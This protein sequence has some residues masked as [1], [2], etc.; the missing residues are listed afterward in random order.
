MTLRQWLR[1]VMGR[2]PK[3]REQSV[4]DTSLRH[5]LEVL[6]QDLRYTVRVIRRTG[7]L[8]VAVVLTLI[9]GLAI[10]SVAFSV[11]NGVPSREPLS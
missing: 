10:N 1:G 3:E 5:E 7:P 11:L 6:S 8:S 2:P 4:R 9:V